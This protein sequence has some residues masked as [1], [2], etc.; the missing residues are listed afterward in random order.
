MASQEITIIADDSK[1]EYDPFAY[2]NQAQAQNSNI[3][4]KPV[5]PTVSSSQVGTPRVQ[6]FREAT[7]TDKLA[8]S[9]ESIG[10]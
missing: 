4:L 6:Y 2:E 1:T 10:Y 8:G 5:P 9:R 7:K 3:G